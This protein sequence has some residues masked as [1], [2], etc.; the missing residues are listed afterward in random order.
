MG[1]RGEGFV[2]QESKLPAGAE[3]VWARATSA[4]GINHELSPWL[5]MTSPKDLRGIT[6]ADVSP[7]QKLG[8]SWILFLRV[9]P[10]DYD[11][12]AIA[13]I[14]PGCRFL[15]QSTML[16]MRR[17]QHE[18]DVQPDERGC[19]LTDRLTFELRGPLARVPGSHRIASAIVRAIFKHRHRGLRA[20]F[21][22]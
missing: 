18:R 3:T 22:G 20:Y 7:G 12:I 1:T 4:E 16:S 14:G 6:I 9:L 17:W 8:R 13:E 19:V 10:V 5:R 2:Q 21:G 11:D 15:E